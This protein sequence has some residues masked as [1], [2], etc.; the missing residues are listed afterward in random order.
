[1]PQPLDLAA[2]SVVFLLE[3]KIRFI[4]FVLAFRQAPD[5]KHP[6]LAKKGKETQRDN[7]NAERGDHPALRN[8]GWSHGED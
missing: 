6:A 7:H 3:E 8:S 4:Q 1:M 5:V 2:Q